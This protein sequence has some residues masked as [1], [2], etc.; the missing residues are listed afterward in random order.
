MSIGVGLAP[1][2]VPDLSRFPGGV[3]IVLGSP[4]TSATLIAFGLNLAFNRT[5]P[6]H[7]ADDEAEAEK[8]TRPTSTTLAEYVP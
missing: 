5:R 6:A 2:V 7:T 4:V 8:Q 1:D 3:R